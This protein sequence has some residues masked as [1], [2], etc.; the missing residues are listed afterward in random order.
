MRSLFFLAVGVCIGILVAP[1][2]GSETRKKVTDAMN[3][4][5]SKLKKKA[6]NIYEEEIINQESP[7]YTS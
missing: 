2:K 4:I 1:D 7:R 6:E 5:K 3:D